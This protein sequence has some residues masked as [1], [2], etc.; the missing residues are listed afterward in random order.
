MHLD[1]F[2][3]DALL[4]FEATKWAS[5]MHLLAVKCSIRPLVG[6]GRRLTSA[7]SPSSSGS[8][9]RARMLT[10]PQP[11]IAP[12][13]QFKADQSVDD[14]RVTWWDPVPVC[15]QSHKDQPHRSPY[16]TS[17]RRGKKKKKIPCMKDWWY[18]LISCHCFHSVAHFWSVSPKQ[19]V[20]V[21]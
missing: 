2:A 12:D 15:F 19:D 14:F 10:K 9:S 21:K 3:S 1:L 16:Q 20:I 4:S 6:Q 18:M 17:H 5:F 8:C 13:V 7:V 11:E